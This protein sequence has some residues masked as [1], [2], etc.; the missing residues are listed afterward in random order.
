MSGIFYI[1]ETTWTEITSKANPKPTGTNIQAKIDALYAQ[2]QNNEFG[3]E[4]VVILLAAGT[5]ELNIR[6]GYYTTVL[7]EE[8]LPS[9]VR[10]VGNVIVPNRNPTPANC[11]TGYALDN[12]WRGVENLTVK[13]ETWPLCYPFISRAP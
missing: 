11:E 7:G 1:T 12:F 3:R 4:R 13:P 2:Q 10:V 5:H 6:V 9:D 8:Q